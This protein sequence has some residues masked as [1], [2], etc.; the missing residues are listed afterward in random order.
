MHVRNVLN[1]T[2]VKSV[3]RQ[4]QYVLGVRIVTVVTAEKNVLEPWKTVIIVSDI[5]VKIVKKK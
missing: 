3:E 4:L 5:I 2:A 1:R